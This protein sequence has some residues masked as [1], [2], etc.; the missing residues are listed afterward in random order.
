MEGLDYPEVGE[1]VS[2]HW[3]YFLERVDELPEIDKYKLV[4]HDYIEL[5]LDSRRGK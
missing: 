3:G 4:L 5:V 1:I 2:G